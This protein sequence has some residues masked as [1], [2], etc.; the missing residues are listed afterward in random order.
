MLTLFSFK[1]SCHLLRGVLTR[2]SKVVHGTRSLEFW[3]HTDLPWF[4]LFFLLL[5]CN[6]SNEVKTLLRCRVLYEKS[7]NYTILL[8]FKSVRAPL[9]SGWW[10]DAPFIS[11]G[12]H[13]Y[14][15]R[16][17]M[18][19]TINLESNVFE[20]PYVLADSQNVDHQLPAG[21]LRRLWTLMDFIAF[22]RH[23]TL[24][25]YSSFVSFGLLQ[26]CDGMKI[27]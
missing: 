20:H 3:F 18:P 15:L 8:Y 13:L 17:Y 6:P 7:G 25:W 10:S 9:V 16:D 23:V 27:Y 1:F 2:D 12:K 4:I 22:W 19:C 14:I 26:L 24:Q 5:L 21:C 11:S